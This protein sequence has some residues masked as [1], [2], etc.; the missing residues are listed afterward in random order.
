MAVRFV[1]ARGLCLSALIE[2]HRPIP[3]DFGEQDKLPQFCD[4][5]VSH[6]HYIC[7][8]SWQSFLMG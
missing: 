5:G 2:G 4:L 3:E 7:C 8:H 1:V 6:A